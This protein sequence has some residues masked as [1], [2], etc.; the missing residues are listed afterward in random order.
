[1]VD[2]VSAH[3]LFPWRRKSVSSN[4]QFRNK[5]N[6]RTSSIC[7]KNDMLWF[8]RQSITRSARL[9]DAR[10]IEIALA[11]LKTIQVRVN[12]NIV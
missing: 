4:M 5:S 8:H 2:V 9:K 3:E 11:I 7:T 12:K 6:F 10:R 1:V